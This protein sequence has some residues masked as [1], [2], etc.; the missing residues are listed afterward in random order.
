MYLDRLPHPRKY[1]LLAEGKL[2]H[3]TSK[4]ANAVLRY[5]PETAVAIIDS[6]KTGKTSG[7][8]LGYGG[9]IPIVASLDEGMQKGP[10]ILLIGISPAGGRLPDS[11]IP[12]IRRAIEHKL[13]IVSGLHTLLSK[14]PVFFDAAEQ[15]N[16]EI[17]DL[18]KI[19]PGYKVVARGLWRNRTKPA[20]L[21]VGM[22][23]N[24]GKKTTTLEIQREMNRRNIKSVF[25]PTGQTGVLIADS[26][27]AVNAITS[28]F[29]A[30]SIELAIERSIK[31]DTEYILV[32]GQGALTHQ[33][34][35]GVTL[36]LMHGTMPDAMI[37]CQME[38]RKV[39]LHYKQPFPDMKEVINL[40]E[41][42]IGFFKKSRVIGIGLNTVGMSDDDAIYAVKKYEDRIGLPATDPCRFGSEKL[43]DAVE[44]YFQEVVRD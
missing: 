24:I 32:E 2:G 4:T 34:Y 30:G 14:M 38:S 27:I 31:P 23:C 15:Y 35:S 17:V 5:Q 36:G 22:D 33:G 44:E 6:T 11:W 41:A 42:I 18:R 12:V 39:D 37:M 13:S 28:D 3:T 16:V 8:V 21:T 40:H 43:V 25:V 9:N 10:N 1:L 29:I 20:I 19:P 26:G 7:D